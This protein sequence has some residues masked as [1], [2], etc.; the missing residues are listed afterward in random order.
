[1]S[2]PIGGSSEP[3]PTPKQAAP[4]PWTD[5]ALLTGAVVL[6]TLATLTALHKF[7]IMHYIGDSGCAH[8]AY[9]LNGGAALLV[10]SDLSH[11][12]IKYLKSSEV[13]E[14]PEEYIVP[15]NFPGAQ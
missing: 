1:M 7:P 5:V 8:L 2:F 3:L 9:A 10:L 12:L 15:E 6:G 4:F 13:E 11:Q 14:P